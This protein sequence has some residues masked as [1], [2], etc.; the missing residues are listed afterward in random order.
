MALAI[1]ILTNLLLKVTPFMMVV[2]VATIVLL[3]LAIAAMALGFGAL[4]PQFETENAAQIPT[5]YGGLVFMMSTIALLAA[6][7]V[8]EAVPV[9][10]Y[11][12]AALAGEPV[13]I[14]ARMIAA[15][16]VVALICFLATLIPLRVGL[17]KMEQF[18]F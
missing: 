9:S 15:F 14:D 6:V 4:Y 13:S 17:K 7:I 16:A 5:S 2:S 11:L 8:V 1:T 3:T 12:R 10:G 18:E